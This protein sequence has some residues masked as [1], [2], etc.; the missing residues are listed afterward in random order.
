MF[1]RHVIEY[2]ISN[3]SG[4]PRSD[5]ALG[6]LASSHQGVT[7]LFMDIVGFTTMSKQV[8]CDWFA[9]YLGT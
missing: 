5:A 9:P 2:M 1:P 6:S 7:I 3:S 8:V 4:G